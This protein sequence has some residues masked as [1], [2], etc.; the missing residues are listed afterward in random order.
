MLASAES[1][2]DLRRYLVQ[3]LDGLGE[4]VEGTGF[5]CHAEGY[6]LTCWHVVSGWGGP[7][8]GAWPV[9]PLEVHGRLR[10]QDALRSFGYPRGRFDQSGIPIRGEIGGLEAIRIGGVEAL[11]I[12][13]LNLDSVAALVDRLQDP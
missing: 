1:V 10:L 7:A 8:D 4:G 13:G 6:A 5:A 3:V 2:A 11:P 9:L 12:A